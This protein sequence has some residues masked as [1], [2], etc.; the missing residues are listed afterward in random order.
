MAL[1]PWK[2]KRS[3]NGNDNPMANLRHEVDRLFDSV[4]GDPFGWFGQASGLGTAF[5]SVDVSESGNELTVRAELPG[6]KA[7]DLDVSLADNALVLAGEKREQ[8]ERQEGG[9]YHSERR[10]GS[11]RR[12]VPLPCAV[13]PEKVEASFAD[14]VLTVRLHKSPDAQARRIQVKGA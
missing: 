14:G 12:E 7:A 6:V 10:F 4:M 1:I 5:P 13:D 11:F 9:Y 3:E 2:T 8:H